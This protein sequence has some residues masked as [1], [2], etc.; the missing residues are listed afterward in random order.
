MS[1]LEKVKQAASLLENNPIL[2]A[3]D[4]NL[5]YFLSILK[6]NPVKELDF[7]EQDWLSFLSL[8][9][10]QGLAALM[11]WKTKTLPENL[12]PPQNIVDQLR[13]TFMANHVKFLQAEQQLKELYQ[14]FNQA[15]IKV[16]LLKGPA[17]ALTIYPHPALRS[18]GDID[19]F[20]EPEKAPDAEKVLKQLGYQGHK[21][22]FNTFQELRNEESF[23]KRNKSFKMV[24]LHWGLHAFF[25]ILNPPTAREYLDKSVPVKTPKFTFLTLNPIDSLIHA[26][27]HMRMTHYG[28][29]RL[30]WVADIAMLIKELKDPADW[31]VLKLK[32]QQI[33]ANLVMEQSLKL[34]EVIFNAV[35]PDEF[36]KKGGWPKATKQEV[37]NFK[38]AVDRDRNRFSWLRARW[39]K[40]LRILKQIKLFAQ[41]LIDYS[42]L[43]TRR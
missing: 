36:I 6:N 11:Y 38:Y 33:G 39:P 27:I 41:L 43:K 23:T 40:H 18:F 19:I 29:S 2:K 28:S 24:E 21:E 12:K 35:P 1:G 32:S 34:A 22:Q 14:A 17:Y 13:Q 15:G 37:A 3:D 4:K 20:V 42:G 31:N 10:S 16:L 30:S 26:A 25:G 7:S 9:N 8:V 5:T